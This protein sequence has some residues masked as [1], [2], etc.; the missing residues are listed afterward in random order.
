MNA[1]V[2]CLNI[3]GGTT[4]AALAGVL[5]VRKKVSR[6][7]RQD[8]HEVGGY[9]LAIIG[10]LYAILVGLIV[11]NAEG[12]VDTASAKAV[13]ESNKLTNIYHC[14]QRFE[15]QARHKICQSLHQYAAKVVKQDWAEVES[16]DQKEA[17][18]EPYRQLWR[19]IVSYTPRN[20]SEQECYA[21]LL[22][23]MEELSDARKYRMVEAKSELSPILWAVLIAGG[24]MIVL[25]TYF[26][27]VESLMTQLLMTASVVIFLSMNIYLIYICQNPYRPEL[28]AKEAGFGFSFSPSWFLDKTPE[29]NTGEVSP[30]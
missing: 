14:C 5:I 21:I 16:G 24:V 7:S 11:V 25:F 22:R 13:T 18:I 1:L 28:G 15:P 17:T 29:T 10:T 8:A 27:F 4:V 19:D 12:K 3:V 20:V 6:Q 2:D 26:F 23:D 30:K 9:I